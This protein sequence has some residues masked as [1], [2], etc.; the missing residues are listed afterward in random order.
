ME[1]G[2]RSKAEIFKS[3]L[4]E[5]KI[6]FFNVEEK[7]DEF[8][9]V[10]FRTEINLKGQM[11]PLLVLT[12]DSVYTLIKIRVVAYASKESNQNRLLAYMDKL[13]ASYKAF[14]YSLNVDGDVVLDISLLSDRAFFDTNIVMGMINQAVT[15]LEEVYPEFMKIV[16][17][18]EE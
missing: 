8:N 12:D 16:W 3:F 18:R 15:H 7:N 2:I 1:Q 6:D 17:T 4:E 13:N 10:I 9:A 5:N 11:L 14:K